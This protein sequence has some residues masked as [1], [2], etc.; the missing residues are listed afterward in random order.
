MTATINAHVTVPT[1]AI[2]DLVEFDLYSHPHKGI[3]AALFS[4]TG[5]AGSVDPSDRL[6]RGQVVDQ[7]LTIARFLDEHAKHENEFVVPSIEKYAPELA[8]VIHVVHPL[9]DAR[10]AAI[11]ELAEEVDVTS[12]PRAKAAVHT[13]YLELASFTGA[14]LEHQDFEERQCMAVLAAALPV[15]DLVAINQ[16]IV[17]SIPPE[18]MAVALSLM[19]PAMNIDDRIELLGGMQAGAPP[20]VFAGVCALAESVLTPAAWSATAARL[21]IA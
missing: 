17:G 15:A 19:L 4:V 6:A 13:L 5:C 9:L 12:G 1:L 21:G 2:E 7:V 14:Y 20:E 8:D 18:D 16:A 3:R 11:R 10:V